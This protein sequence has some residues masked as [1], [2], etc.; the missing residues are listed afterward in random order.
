[1]ATIVIV[2]M[3]QLK[4]NCELVTF[5]LSLLCSLRR[6]LRCGIMM[7]SLSLLSQVL[8]VVIKY[9]YEARQSRGFGFVT[10]GNNAAAQAA[11]QGLIGVE[12]M[13]RKLNIEVVSLVGFMNDF[14]FCCFG[15]ISFFFCG[16]I[17]IAFDFMHSLLFLK[18]SC[19]CET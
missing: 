17:E 9:N 6:S 16:K 10:V 5:F 11:M 13:G 7:A 19:I 15:W 12:F 18:R 4:R 14:F 8:K 3:S 2:F 1:M